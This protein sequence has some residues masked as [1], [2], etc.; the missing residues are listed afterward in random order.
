MNQ[1]IKF[2]IKNIELLDFS[3]QYPGQLLNEE[4]KYK[5]NINIEQ[6]FS[7]PQNLVAVTTTIN[8]IREADQQ[9]Q[10]AV[11][12]NCIYMVDNLNQYGNEKTKTIHLPDQFNT[13]LIS[14]SLSTARGIMFSQFKGTFL[15]NAILPII[16][17][18]DFKKES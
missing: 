17:P 15:H 7:E 14:I 16:D 3:L 6:K 2:Q 1:E 4:T 9:M 5:F 10:G 18:T 11:T 12:T 8:I 13:T